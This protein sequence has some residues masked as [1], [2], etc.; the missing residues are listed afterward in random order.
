MNTGKHQ[1]DFVNIVVGNQSYVYNLNADDLEG[2]LYQLDS[3]DSFN[4]NGAACNT[5]LPLI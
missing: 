3:I 2:C 1:G 5:G 4:S